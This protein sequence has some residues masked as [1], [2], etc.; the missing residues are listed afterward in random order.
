[1]EL[2]PF[3]KLWDKI[4]DQYID[5]PTTGCWIWTGTLINGYAMIKVGGFWLMVGRLLYE[6]FFCP[7]PDGFKVFRRC[8]NRKCINPD[9]GMLGTPASRVLV[10]GAKVNGHRGGP[11]A[12]LTAADVKDI[13]AR[14][15][16]AK[17]YAEQYGVSPSCIYGIWEG[18]RWK[19]V[20]A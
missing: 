4:K 11:E 13:K 16:P 6:R 20:T 7:I 14:Q 2:L 15:R 12:N 9:H 5:D 8:L 1:M 10:P 18:R 3:P 17:A 19:D